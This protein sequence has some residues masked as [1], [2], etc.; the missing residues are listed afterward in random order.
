MKSVIFVLSVVLC[1]VFLTPSPL[2]AQHNRAVLAQ[3]ESVLPMPITHFGLQ[4]GSTFTTGFAGSTLFSQTVA[5][6]F[7]WNATQRFSLVV[8]SVFSSGQL[9][10]AFGLFPKAIS[11]SVIGNKI[12]PAHLFSA[13]VYALGAYQANPRLTVFGASWV[14]R[15]N[16][17][18]LQPQ[19][20]PNAFNVNPHGLMM[21]FDYRISENFSFGAQ[22]N[23]SQ[24]FNPFNPFFN[25][26]V[27]H[28][29]GFPSS[30]FH[31]SPVW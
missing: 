30:P 2:N 1:L 3:G 28:R 6:H 21:G 23:V 10:G 24:G 22:V 31:R 18:S 16:M 13:T 25:Q 29:S 14:E 26:G 4:A 20:N 27:F 19:M 12:T 9:S 11:S 7:K 17:Q 8:G 5:P 15:N